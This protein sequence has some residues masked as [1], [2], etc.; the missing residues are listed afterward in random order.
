MPPFHTILH[1]LEFNGAVGLKHK[2][3]QI[4][5]MKKTDIK[6]LIVAHIGI[7][8]NWQA[9]VCL[10]QVEVLCVFQFNSIQKALNECC[11]EL[12]QVHSS[13]HRQRPSEVSFVDI[14]TW[15]LWATDNILKGKIIKEVA[16]FRNWIR[17]I[18]CSLW[19]FAAVLVGT[20]VRKESSKLKLFRG[21]I[22]EHES[23]C[24]C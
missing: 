2:Q 21:L 18:P 11:R 24:S 7:F 1:F 8:L 16:T 14:T 10:L 5:H 4:E 19:M 9:S 17:W 15:S 3:P 6:Y 23:V 12:W 22:L 13:W 20:K